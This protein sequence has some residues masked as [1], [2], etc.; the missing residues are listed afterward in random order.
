MGAK[1]L[2][3]GAALL[4]RRQRSSKPGSGGRLRIKIAAETSVRCRWARSPGRHVART[5]TVSREAGRQ[6]GRKDSDN[7]KAQRS[8]RRKAGS[9]HR[10]G[11][12]TAWESAN[13]RRCHSAVVLRG[14]ERT[15]AA[16][17]GDAAELMSKEQCSGSDGNGRR[18]RGGEGSALVGR[19]RRGRLLPGG[20]ANLSQLD[21]LDTRSLQLQR[22]SGRRPLPVH[23]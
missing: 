4:E 3:M 11:D 23:V 20:C 7:T 18:A 8:R 1:K 22:R 9:S 19:A 5:G 16:S 12:G 6:E 13:G 14:S 17:R 21:L 15:L 2:A 10:H